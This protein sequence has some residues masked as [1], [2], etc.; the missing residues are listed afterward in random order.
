VE[1]SGRRPERTVYR[2]TEAG[3][4]VLEES[5]RRLVSEPV[6]EYTSFEAGLVTIAHLSRGDVVRSL[7]ERAIR[8]RARAAEH[9]SILQDHLGM[10]LP[11]LFV[12]EIDY[13]VDHCAAQAVWCDRTAA[14][15]ERGEIA[16]PD[17][18]HLPRETGHLLHV[19]E[20]TPRPTRAARADGAGRGVAR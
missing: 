11:H 1:R 13:Q 8:L 14:A 9:H 2:I 20:P 15:I 5:V 16:W 3:R 18:E 6:N 17:L 10:G 12:L 7:R 19:D 4:T